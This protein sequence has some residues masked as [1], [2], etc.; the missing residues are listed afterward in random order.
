VA[1]LGTFILEIR[2]KAF[3]ITVGAVGGFLVVI[4]VMRLWAEPSAARNPWFWVTTLIGVVLSAW[5]WRLLRQLR[6]P[7]SSG[8]PS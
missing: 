6:G 3:L 7:A 1:A 5:A 4:H 8:T 2:M